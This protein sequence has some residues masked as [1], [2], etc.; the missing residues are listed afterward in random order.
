MHSRGKT[1][2]SHAGLTHKVL[3]TFLG[4]IRANRNA[5]PLGRKPY[6]PC[7]HVSRRDSISEE[8][9]SLPALTGLPKTGT[10][11]TPDGDWVA[12]YGAIGAGRALTLRM[13]ASEPSCT[14]SRA[15]QR[16][17]VFLIASR[18]RVR[19]GAVPLHGTSRQNRR[20]CVGLY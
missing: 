2:A 4:E 17:C 14:T 19:L 9:T 16:R 1:H 3:F 13:E 6:I 20:A 15:S 18:S 12:G 8:P 7:K 11:P 5:K 10:P